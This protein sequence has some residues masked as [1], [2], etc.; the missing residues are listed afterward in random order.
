MT[1]PH[2]SI[3]VTPSLPSTVSILPRKDGVPGYRIT[4]Y[5]ASEG[6]FEYVITARNNRGSDSVHLKVVVESRFGSFSSFTAAV[7]NQNEIVV[8]D[9]STADANYTISFNGTLIFD[10]LRYSSNLNT[11]TIGSIFQGDFTV[12]LCGMYKIVSFFTIRNPSETYHVFLFLNNRELL[13]S[14]SSPSPP[15]PVCV[16]H[17]FNIH[18][19]AN[20]DSLWKYHVSVGSL[21]SEWRYPYYNDEA[22][23][24]NRNQFLIYPD[25]NFLYLR[26]VFTVSLQTQYLLVQLV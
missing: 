25:N 3:T 9:T 12:T 18:E 4:G 14:E 10:R 17:L 23:P 8:V 15:S 6:E 19:Y 26:K 16:T 13:F 22:W 24:S 20:V 21:P 5:F 7:S 1:Q 2:Y 11:V